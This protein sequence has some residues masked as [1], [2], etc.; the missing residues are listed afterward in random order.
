MAF[1]INKLESNILR[2]LAFA[3]GHDELPELEMRRLVGEWLK[4]ASKYEV[5]EKF[6]EWNGIINYTQ[7]ILDALESIDKA[8]IKGLPPGFFKTTKKDV[9]FIT[10]SIVGGINGKK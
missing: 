3:L 7:T 8:E 1:D 10:Q 6:L 2:D 9:D 4:T 5:F